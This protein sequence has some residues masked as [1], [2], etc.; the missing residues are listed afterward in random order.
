MEKAIDEGYD[1]HLDYTRDVMK[2]MTYAREEWHM[3][4]PE[5]EA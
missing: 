5:E 3:K 2:I 1:M 4:Y